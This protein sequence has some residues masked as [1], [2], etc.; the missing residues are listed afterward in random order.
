[1]AK[2]RSEWTIADMGCAH[3]GVITVPLYDSQGKEDVKYIAQHSDITGIIIAAEH[4][5]L[6]QPLA[7]CA[8]FA[9]IK[10]IIVMDMRAD[11]AKL[12]HTTRPE[13]ATYTMEPL[14]YVT[15]TLDA[16][17]ADE[18]AANCS[19]ITKAFSNVIQLG[20][21]NGDVP[22]EEITTEDDYSIVYTSG[23][24]G[25][26][27]GV[28]I[29]HQ[30]CIIG[31]LVLG[32]RWPDRPAFMLKKEIYDSVISYLPMAHIFMRVVALL[33]IKNIASFGFFQG[34]AKL[35]IEDVGVLKPTVM[36]A[37]PRVLAK[38]FDAVTGKLVDKAAVA[39]FLFSSGYAAKKRALFEGNTRG[40]T[41]MWDR[42]L[43][44]KTA[45]VLGGNVRLF[46]S[47]S[48]PLPVQVNEFIQIVFG[49]PIIEGY[50]MTETSSSGTAQTFGC[51]DLGNV[52]GPEGPT[53]VKLC[54]VPELDYL[55]T[56]TPNPRGEVCIKG[57]IVFKGYY[58]CPDKTAE[59]MEDGWFHTGDIGEMLDG[60]RLK[61]I[62][63][64]RNIFKMAQGEFVCGTAIEDTC[65]ANCSSVNNI[66][67]Y[68]NRYESFLVAVVVPHKSVVDAWWAELGKDAT[69]SFEDRL[70]DEDIVMKVHEEVS[71]ACKDAKLRG[72]EHPRAIILHPTEWSIENNLLTP[73]MK[74]K[75]TE[76]KN[77]YLSRLLE[78]YLRIKNNVANP[79]TLTLKLAAELSVD[80]VKAVNC[81]EGGD[82]DEESLTTITFTSRK[83]G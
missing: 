18:R 56:D 36:P 60:N 43:F 45:Q 30:N 10:D 68:G 39:R 20:R 17:P 70:I 50:G 71:N 9:N 40:T 7:A 46:F 64:K 5:P 11:D 3:R 78:T 34:N 23:T 37:V 55:V 2:N 77:M 4:L 79:N 80:A 59:V 65:S 15:M 47:G 49:A 24:T 29:T 21:D 75:R 6:L 57:G 35:L 82:L 61:L 12:L 58:K 74:P 33:L 22:D 13:L 14:E 41:K 62:D 16:T 44:N 81:G 76:L 8:E 32:S 73:S 48:A 66:F 83:S 52:G 1:M 72:F 31:A 26:P 67:V 53:E 28:V 51:Q 27:K 42:L 38:L 54:N 25:N 63:R 19:I 69:V